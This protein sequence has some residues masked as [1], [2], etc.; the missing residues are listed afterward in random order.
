MRRYSFNELTATKL[1]EI[2][3]IHHELPQPEVYEARTSPR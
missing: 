3:S 1:L 2:A